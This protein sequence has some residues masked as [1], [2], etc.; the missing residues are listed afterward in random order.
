VQTPPLNDEEMELSCDPHFGVYAQFRR[1]TI[2]SGQAEDL[3]LTT[4]DVVSLS[5]ASCTGGSVTQAG[6]LAGTYQFDSDGNFIRSVDETAARYLIDAGADDYLVEFKSSTASAALSAQHA[7]IVTPVVDSACRASAGPMQLAVGEKLFWARR[8]SAIADCGNYPW[9]PGAALAL[10]FAQGGTVEISRPVVNGVAT[11]SS[12]RYFQ[13]TGQCAGCAEARFASPD[14]Q[15]VL[16]GDVGASGSFV[17]GAPT[18]ATVGPSA[19]DVRV[20]P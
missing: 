6:A 15:V 4:K 5:I 20:V 10:Q 1:F 17:L 9:C 19:V 3:R 8:A 13:C 12:D 18:A 14:Q 11:W 7:E 2:G 16:A